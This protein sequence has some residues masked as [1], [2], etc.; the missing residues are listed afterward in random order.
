M[1]VF[2]KYYRRLLA[3]NASQIFGSSNNADSTGNYQ[4]LV[5][6]VQKI[7]QDPHQAVK[8]AESID[9]TEPE[10]FRDFDV[11]TFMERFRM[12]PVSK[13]MLALSLKTA[14]KADLRTKADA[15]LSNN[16]QNLL[17]A[18][19]SP[20]SV[21]DIPVPYLCTLLERLIQDPPRN[22]NDDSKGNLLTAVRDRFD[23]LNR[24]VPNDVWA[25]LHLTELLGPINQLVRLVQRT[26]P[27]GTSSLETCREMLAA[28]EI[29]DISY[30]QVASVLLY[31]VISQGGQA[32]N[33]AIFVAALRDH[34]QG[35]RLDWQDVVHS[36]DREG[37]RVVKSQFLALYNALLP[38]ALEYENF[39]IQLLWGGQWTQPETQLSFV[40]AFLSCS[41]EELDATEIP[42]LRKAF[43]I[44]D[45]EDASENIR[46]Y[47]LQAV[48]HPL[49]SLDATSALFNMIFQSQ[50]TYLHATSLR[51]PET[52]INPHTVIFIIAI[53]ALPKPWGGLQEQAFK[54]LFTPFL[55]KQLRGDEFVFHGLWKRDSRWL[56]EKLM[57]TYNAD[58]MSITFI[59][60]HA[61]EHKWLDTLTTIHSEFGVDLAAFAHSQGSLDM[62]KWLEHAFQALPGVFPAALSGFVTDKARAEQATQK[63][64]MAVPQTMP[65]AVKTVYSFL[66]FLS[67]YLPDENL[68][69]LHRMC[70]NAYPRLI[71]YGEG[72]DQ[73]IDANGQE[74]NAM[75]PE[76]DLA[77]QEHFKK[78]YNKE[79][80]V[81]EVVE[82]LR[83]YKHS[84]DPAEQDLFACM[85]AGLFDEYNCFAEYPAD[86]LATTAV[87]FGS[88]IN[89]NLLSSIAL[90]AGLAMVLEALQMSTSREEKMYKFGVQALINFQ[91][92]LP[93]WPA[94]C[95]RLL[96]VPNLQGT[97]IWPIADDVWRRHIQEN[98]NGDR[99][100]G[101]QRS[102]SEEFAGTEPTVPAF[103]CL[104]VDPPLRSDLYEDPEEEVQDKVLFVLNNVSERNL[105]EKLGSLK[106]ALEEK[107]LQWFASYMV[108]ERA[109]LQHNYQALYLN[110]LEL[111][112]D[113]S[114]WA[115]VLRETY[116]S[117]F[118]LLNSE[119]IAN[120]GEERNH[121]K[122]LGSWLGSLT[123]ARDKP[124]KHRN[125][126]FRD[127]LLEAHASN[128]LLFVVP[129][130]CKVLVAVQE[131]KIYRPPNPW[132]VEILRLLVELYHYADLKTVLKF[133]IEL[134]CNRLGYD[135]T[136]VE[137][138]T[139]IRNALNFEEEFPAGIPD[140]LEGFTDLSLASLNRPGSLR[141]VH[142]RFSPAAIVA[143]L[144]DISSRIKYPSL[145]NNLTPEQER[146][147]FLQAAQH[148]INEI[149]FPVV[150]RSVTIAA[151]SAAQ[152]VTKDF[153]T[154]ADEAHFRHAA[155]SMVKA[156]AG[157]L[158]MVTCREPLR[159]SMSN[160][161]RQLA[162]NL[163]G[164]GLPEGVIVMFVN[165]NADAVCKVVEEAAEKHAEMIID[166]H[167][168]EGIQIRQAHRQAGHKDEPFAY[169]HVHR[170]AYTIPEP[171]KPS[172]FGSLKPEQLAIYEDFGSSR[173]ISNHVS[174][175]TPDNRPQVPDVIQAAFES[176]VPNMATPGEVPALL[177][178][179]PQPHVLGL[180]A[181]TNAGNPQFN[182]F[183]ER[184]NVDQLLSE[185]HRVAKEAPEERIKDLIPSTPTREVYDQLVQAIEV[186]GALRDK[187]AEHIALQ[188]IHFL[189]GEAEGRLEIEL[190]IQLL[191]HLCQMS[192]LAAR[193]L[194]ST[195]AQFED[196]RI[197]HPQVTI[198]LLN[199]RMITFNRIDIL[200]AE[201]L[202]Q[203]KS[204][205]LEFLAEL[206]DETLLVE[207]PVALR[208]DLVHSIDALSH[209]VAGDPSLELG[210]AIL[211]RLDGSNGVPTPIDHH[212]HLEYVFDE[213]VQLSRPELI[214]K[215]IMTYIQQLH[216]Q[217]LF[218]G[219]NETANFIRTCLEISIASYEQEEAF[220]FGGSLDTA[221]LQIDALARL[222]VALVVYQ[223]EPHGAVKPS[224]PAFLETMMSLL[225]VLQV[226]HS[227]A[228]GEHANQ[229][230]FY[231]LYSSILCELASVQAKMLEQSYPDIL[232]V[233]A[234]AF[235]ALQP[236]YFP[237]FAFS[238]LGLISHRMFMPAILR[239]PTPEINTATDA[240]S[241]SEMQSK[242]WEAFLQ[243]LEILFAYAGELVKPMDVPS[244]SRTFYRALLRVLLILHHDF[245][246]FLADHHMQ[247]CN[248]I[249][250][251]CAQLRN[252]VVSAVPSAMPELPDPFTVGF[253][254]D[255][256]E[257]VRKNPNIRG[258]FVG[259]LKK[260]GIY[261]T[262]EAIFDD[263]EQ[264][265]DF[266]KLAQALSRPRGE[267]SSDGSA[268]SNV[269][270][271]LIHALVIYIGSTAIAAAGTKGPTFNKAAPQAKMLHQL[272]KDL[273]AGV[274][275]H[276]ISAIANQL[277]YPN[278][279][280]HYFSY[281]LLD[282]FGFPSNDPQSQEVQE[283]VSRV[284]LER[285]ILHRP[286]PWGLLITILE[287]YKNSNYDF[288][289][290][291]F[292]Q[293]NSEVERLFG[294]LFNNIR[295]PRQP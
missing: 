182:T 275:Y 19:K 225:I 80:D 267:E 284:L 291:P 81:R 196:D 115:E 99:P 272:M 16:F 52:V 231:R 6:E 277:R 145:A 249:P 181:M 164:D 167:L 254:V 199:T 292:I 100:N 179:G 89:F 224:K 171:F 8:I 34:R 68:V 176:S 86:A 23:K 92:R 27:R 69:A 135:H 74:G 153:A 91:S 282:I 64:P 261:D 147:I 247:L 226:H 101:V 123:L 194:S 260:G 30:M 223:D 120:S 288:F 125:I 60:Q 243:L 262:V 15:I 128:R 242:G 210:K 259:L 97:E 9:T 192:P 235:V 283:Q 47:A 286:H 204:V 3:N 66:N 129:F 293:A 107:H 241:V 245:P 278:S 32:Y 35:K 5:T 2:V 206:V 43:T 240:T 88:I 266:E 279:H 160:N 188:V 111:F 65:L 230:V 42:R 109:K 177:R 122:Q 158:A 172:R 7:R 50:D 127:L 269:D 13:S 121:L 233:L 229:K 251:H 98:L 51:I 14:S 143:N 119:T 57:E 49:V 112:D 169:P 33:P 232:L 126:S 95:E 73:I 18:I 258:D 149:I 209:W 78:L 28:A 77:M 63:D 90:Q 139:T 238:W 11:S 276:F 82:A 110:I 270:D 140:G 173:S 168:R 93:E 250:A 189:Y 185:L 4:L 157:S 248:S 72:F 287:L 290:L 10:I 61:K 163:P 207:Y 228:R 41:P 105:N 138:A 12:D 96:G 256:V 211:N 79:S 161:V 216:K 295:S 146:Q 55:R 102:G 190:M 159:M 246:E 215:P 94:L 257:D 142:E 178:Q 212:Q 187:V 166:D 104:H 264:P 113:K 132:T 186:N 271:A 200:L 218:K 48:R 131:S 274:R 154:E 141:S 165:E 217:G 203:R 39:D 184:L 265:G 285:L 227:Q 175:I 76:A 148:A 234:K 26:G 294:A 17:M 87:L 59:F 124:I 36:F 281:A 130:A 136:H 152:L 46:E 67:Q 202:S 71:N 85:I 236:K 198:C 221:Y 222:I 237:G 1:E 31:M 137:P 62:D 220:P 114:L 193:A 255:R 263:A 22:W 197:F 162:R 244:M 180:Q 40:V 144:P 25:T 75:S 116:I 170:Y 44:E 201:A 117:V 252:L 219:R 150:E 133:E 208:S 268:A 156:L 155:H 174:N 70:I 253:K 205:A 54:Q 45:F 20:E 103:T 151:I 239:I 118:R 38:L 108:E 56:V 289:K 195:L 214:D 191:A 183:P 37:L 58:P 134:L 84:E 29:R 273:K 106:E 83:R 280:T 24:P 53:A 21:D 213:W